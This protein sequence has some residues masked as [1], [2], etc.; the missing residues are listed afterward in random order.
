MLEKITSPA[1]LKKLK[2]SELPKLCEEIREKIIETVSENGG[3]LGSN[4]G[5]V[6]TIVAVHRVFDTPDDALIFDVGHQ[7]YA[8][9]LLTGRYESFSTLRKTGGVSGFVNIEES[10]YDPFTEGHSG[11]ALSQAL[12]LAT[13]KELSG[14]SNYVVAIIGDGSFTNGMIYEAL[15]NC[16]AAGRRLIIILNDNE[17]SISKNVGGLSNHLTKIRTSKKY[18]AI[19]HK[20]KKN[21]IKIPYIGKPLTNAARHV[22]D[23]IKRV[24]VSEN[25]FECMGIDYIGTV[26]G[27]NIHKMLS[28]L[29]EAKTK[30]VCT[31]VHIHTKKGKGYAPA[32]NTPEKY[33]STGKF[34]R[35]S[36]EALK[37]SSESFSSVFGKTVCNLAKEDSRICAVTA[38]M[39]EGTGLLPF[40][41]SYPS[42]FFDVGI[43]EEHAVTFA[44]GL[45]KGGLLPVVALYSTF[46]QRVYDQLWHD[47]A[48]QKLPFVLC[49]DRAGAVEGDGITHQGLF[50]VSE[51]SG[52]PGIEIY[53]PETY[54]ELEES[55]RRATMN[56]KLSVV[57][58]PKGCE[59]DYDRSEFFSKGDYTMATLGEGVPFAAICTYGRITESVYLGAKAFHEKTG[60]PV[61]FVKLVKIYPLDKEALRDELS[62]ASVMYFAEEGIESGGIGEKLASFMSEIH[63][64]A[65]TK[66]RGA[67]DF[68]AHG[69]LCDINEKLGF[70]PSVVENDIES[71]WNSLLSENKE[72]AGVI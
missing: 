24:L 21:F 37:A 32:E 47:V 1:E 34:E 3:H 50:D 5:I 11:T 54:G 56:K 67:T 17:M 45:S 63:S 36:G 64:G 12:G 53:S 68:V 18:F 38:A 41:E 4:L 65:K 60:V 66:L 26:D 13:A 20:I 29:E 69:S 25:L 44:A 51:F 52:I 10:P 31:L 22:R 19:K 49:L 39:E 30:D 46:A 16:K 59:S 61:K 2:S 23:F 15:N 40:K 72:A 48:I 27:N 8:H 58:Y 35:G 7:C 28:V 33:H 14:S 62:G 55:L 57:R 70:T 42:R 6:E 9:K 71:L 43:A